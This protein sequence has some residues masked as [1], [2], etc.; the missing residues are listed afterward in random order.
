MNAIQISS[1]LLNYEYTWSAVVL[2]LRN[3]TNRK[4]LSI[5]CIKIIIVVV[6]DRQ[7]HDNVEVTHE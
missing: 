7:K 3:G 5:C 1:R 2:P 6:D 4:N